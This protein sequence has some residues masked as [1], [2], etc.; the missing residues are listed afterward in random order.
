MTR[1]EP[2]IL[3]PMIASELLSFRKRKRFERKDRGN[4][5]S[6]AA[7]VSCTRL[8][9]IRVSHLASWTENGEA[10]RAR[11]VV[12]GSRELRHYSSRKSYA[13]QLRLQ[14]DAAVS[15]GNCAI[16]LAGANVRLD[17]GQRSLVAR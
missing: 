9:T 15:R 6:E 3:E 1:V 8:K 10:T 11:K 16:M 2:L 5:I 17:S 12:Q 4:A 14:R 7:V 13:K